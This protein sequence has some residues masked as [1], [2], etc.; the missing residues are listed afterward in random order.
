MDVFARLATYCTFSRAYLST[1]Y[2]YSRAWHLLHHVMLQVLVI[3][4]VIAFVVIGQIPFTL[5]SVLRKRCLENHPNL[6][7]QKLSTTSKLTRLSSVNV[8]V[9][10]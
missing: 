2:K 6:A 10:R 9:T 7:L 4:L 3:I 8:Q 1:G 5:T